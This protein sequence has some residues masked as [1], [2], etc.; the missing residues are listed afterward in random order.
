LAGDGRVQRVELADEKFVTCDFAVACV[1]AAA[2]RELLRGTPLASEKAILVDD[3]G[4]TNVADIFAAGDCCAVFDPLFGK[5]RVLDHWDNASV[6]GTLAGTNMAGGDAR[7]DAVNYFFSDVFGI[8][9][10]AWGEAR[11]VTR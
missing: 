8:S 11:L 9:L 4:R 5:H 3:H 2:N 6:T 1:G 10:S 7:Y